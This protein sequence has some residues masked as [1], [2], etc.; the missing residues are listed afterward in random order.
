M[1]RCSPCSASQPLAQSAGGGEFGVAEIAHHAEVGHDRRQP[2]VIAAG[3]TPHHMQLAARQAVGGDA[4]RHAAC[5]NRRRGRRRSPR[6]RP[7]RGWSRA[8]AAPRSRTAVS[9]KN[10]T[11]WRSASQA[12]SFG[13]A[14]REFDT[15]L[16][17]AVERAGELRGAQAPAVVAELGRARQR[18]QPRAHLGR[19]ESFEHR[20]RLRPARD[21][22]QALV[23]RSRCRRAARFPPRR[24]ASA[25][26]A[27][28]NRPPAGRSR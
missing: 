15:Q 21:R 27:A 18:R 17:R 16:V 6:P 19:Q 5:G 4:V 12:A 26:R 24:R 14:S 23:Q 10:V 7:S 2:R 20:P 8:S 22:Q 3:S 9:R 25:W 13:I 28:S 11:P 1:A